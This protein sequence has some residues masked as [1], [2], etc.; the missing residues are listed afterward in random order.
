MTP[1]I[2]ALYDSLNILDLQNSPIFEKI[3]SNIEVTLHTP[4]PTSQPC[5]LRRDFIPD[6]HPYEL[7]LESQFKFEI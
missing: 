2:L 6:H 5:L 4:A 7:E 3:G 1:D